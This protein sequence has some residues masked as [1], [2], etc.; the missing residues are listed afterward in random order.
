[1]AVGVCMVFSS[2]HF[3]SLYTPIIII[4]KNLLCLS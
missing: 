4:I 1:M 2:K 3:F